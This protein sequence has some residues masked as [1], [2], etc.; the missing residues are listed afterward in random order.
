MTTA[1]GGTDSGLPGSVTNVF[2]AANSAVNLYTTLGQGFTINSLNF[3]GAP[4]AAGV[5]IAGPAPLIIN[6]TSANGNAVGSGIT[7]AAGTGAVL[8]SAPVLLGGNQTWSNSSAIQTRC[9]PMPSNSFAAPESASANASIY[10]WIACD[11]RVR[12]SGRFMSRW[13]SSIPSAGCRSMRIPGSSW[14]V[15]WNCA[16]WLPPSTWPSRKG[17]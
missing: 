15:F 13:A 8:I 4:V 12:I 10:L 11:R 1:V 3:T 2:F 16:S 5:T 14:R 9:P 6:A 17:S 7:S